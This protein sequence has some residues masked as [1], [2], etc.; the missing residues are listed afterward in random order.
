MSA[1]KTELFNKLNVS[2]T[3][4]QLTVNC[5]YSKITNQLSVT[6][7]K[8][9]FVDKQKVKTPAC[10]N[11]AFNL[12]TINSLRWFATEK[13]EP[14]WI[15][16]IKKFIPEIFDGL[17]NTDVEYYIAVILV[18]KIIFER[19]EKCITKEQLTEKLSSEGLEVKV[20]QQPAPKGKLC[21]RCDEIF[22]PGHNKVC[23]RTKVS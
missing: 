9:E 20:V 4:S 23:K 5:S 18:A 13:V 7:F 14:K 22:M 10:I 16:L 3:G 8:A 12:A 21:S 11:T 6:E 1:F 19:D 2:T 17:T 15:T